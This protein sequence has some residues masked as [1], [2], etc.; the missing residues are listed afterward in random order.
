[1][2]NIF[3]EIGRMYIQHSTRLCC[4]IIFVLD[5]FIL[6]LSPLNKTTKKTPKTKKNEQKNNNKIN[7]KR[8][9]QQLANK[10]HRVCL[11]ISSVTWHSLE[12]ASATDNVFKVPLTCSERSEGEKLELVLQS[13]ENVQHNGNPHLFSTSGTIGLICQRPN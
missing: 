2:S 11:P 1:M 9:Q 6:F 10:K 4:P 5:L 3:P 8:K 7:K 12:K 13:V